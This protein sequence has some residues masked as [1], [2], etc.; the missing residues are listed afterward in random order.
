M[1]K[2]NT[3]LFFLFLV[4]ALGA[5]HLSAQDCSG[6]VLARK[7]QVYKN[8]FYR[9][10]IVQDRSERGC[11]QDGIGL[12]LSQD[13]AV[14]RFTKEG[15]DLP[16]S[17]FWIAP[18]GDQ[19]N[20]RI[21]KDC[22]EF[23][24][25]WISKDKG[26]RDNPN[27]R[28][29]WVDFGSETLTQMGWW[30]ITL[31]TEYELK[32]NAGDT[33]GQQRALEDL[34]LG[35]Q[36]LRRLDM[37]AQ[38]ILDKTYADRSLGGQQLLCERELVDATKLG[39]WNNCHR[40][41]DVRVKKGARFTP[42]YS[43]YNGFLIRSDVPQSL[44]ELLDDSTD[45]SWNVDAIGG[46]FG[47]LTSVPPSACPPV[48][49]LCFLAKGQYFLSHDQII[50]LFYG[51]LFV[52]KYIPASAKVETCSGEI[53]YPVEMMQK[54]SAGILSALKNSHV[55]LPGS[56]ENCSHTVKLSEC[57]GGNLG[58]TIYGLKKVNEILQ[59]KAVKT[60]LWQRSFFTSMS[61]F[62]A[63][64]NAEFYLKLFCGYKD[65]S[66]LKRRKRRKVIRF[67]KRLHHEILILG[68]DLLFP[69]GDKVAE[70]LGGQDLFYK[71]LCEAPLS[72]PCHAEK[73]YK[74][75]WPWG[76]GARY[77][78][79][80]FECDNVKGW[81]GDRWQTHLWTK[82][83]RP[84]EWIPPRRGNGLDYLALY[85]LYRLAYGASKN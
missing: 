68:N 21:R 31:S 63:S 28:F 8:R 22:D 1:Q 44:V 80:G 34:F 41:W 55:A 3:R 48:D 30:L 7:Y 27:H 36:A 11:V 20:S 73:D 62:N 60:K 84:K 43:G 83:G 46:A 23:G 47:A 26:A 65:F 33:L 50:N 59:G 14:V 70:D 81:E 15:Y 53:F 39:W 79:Q 2:T 64:F 76:G 66:T 35:L 72:G 56:K 42:D 37:Q 9:H 25:S 58:P 67:S 61:I 69:K 13:S 6:D 16:A 82:D 57:E 75:Y 32:R 54:I 40:N 24:I 45:E 10:F 12:V 74:A 4:W 77:W 29:N 19:V 38:Y 52:K 78:P 71:M 5:F 51:F 49:T 17:N 85:N 18:N